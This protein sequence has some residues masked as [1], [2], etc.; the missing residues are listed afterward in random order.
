MVGRISREDTS[1]KPGCQVEAALLK[2]KYTEDMGITKINRLLITDIQEQ[3]QMRR[4]K[5]L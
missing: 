1:L 4:W 3:E 5:H 2:F